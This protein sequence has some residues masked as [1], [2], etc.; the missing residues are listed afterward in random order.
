MTIQQIYD[1][2]IEMGIKTD[3]RGETLVYKRLEK[4]KKDYE[5]LSEKK[6]KYFDKETLRNPYS[7]SRLLFG[8]PNKEVKKVLGGI[9]ANATEILLAD[10]LNEKG[11]N[12]DLL[13]SHHPEGHAL[14]NLHDVMELQVDMYAQQGMPV[15]VA[16]A[17]MA[18]RMKEIELRIHPRNH[19]Q[20][21]DTARLLN[22]PLL[23]LHTIED[24]ISNQFMLDYFK[25]KEFDTVGDVYDHLMEI[26][27]YQEAM[28]GKAGP[29]IVS[30]TRRSRAGRIAIF[31]TGGTNPAKEIYVEWAKLGFG[32]IVDM[33]MK[34]DAIAELQKMHINVINA[35]H[36]SSDSIGANI[37]FDE[38]ESRGIEVIPCSGL[39]RVKRGGSK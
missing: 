27:E 31:F 33:H 4:V 10:R 8:D 37:F 12:I 21:I 25:G 28:R 13:I 26:P 34:E 15:N 38:L 36:M 16:H 1:L 19:N 35:G 30:G 23:A 6:R 22:I 18:K 7:D 17:L 39:I 5:E 29:L 20:T 11:V 14:S 24:N 3:P 32:T 2:A 9:D